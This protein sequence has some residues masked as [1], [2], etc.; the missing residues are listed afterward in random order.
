M[1]HRL[2]ATVPWLLVAASVLFAALL[3]YVFFSGY[4]PARHRVSRLEVELRDLYAREARLHTQIADLEERGRQR[5]QELHALHAERNLLARRL[6]EAERNLA[7][8]RR[9]R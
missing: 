3:F 2:R 5:A 9:R 1:V 4:L 7:L 8:A 6:E